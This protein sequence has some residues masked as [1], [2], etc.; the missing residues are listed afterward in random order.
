MQ[1]STSELGLCIAIE[2]WMDLELC[3]VLYS[4]VFGATWDVV[5]CPGHL[6]REWEGCGADVG[7]THAAASTCLMGGFRASE[8]EAEI[9]E[10]AQ[11]QAQLPRDNGTKVCVI[12][13]ASE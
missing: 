12:S 13:Q 10:P 6:D 2:T 1:V 7:D 4:G 9:Y 3:S 5:S 8:W 11:N